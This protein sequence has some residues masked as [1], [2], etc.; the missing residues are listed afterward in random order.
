MPIMDTDVL[1]IIMRIR[2]LGTKVATV[3]VMRRKI[4]CAAPMGICR[5]RER[6]AEKPKP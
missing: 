6:R 4:I 5:R 1:K 2:V 3:T